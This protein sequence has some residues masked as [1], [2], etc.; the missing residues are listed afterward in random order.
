MQLV[1]LF[2]SAAVTEPFCGL[3]GHA[4]PEAGMPLWCAKRRGLAPHLALSQQQELL[5]QS[6]TYL[7]WQHG[8]FKAEQEA[9]I[10]AQETLYLLQQNLLTVSAALLSAAQAF[11]AGKA[12][13]PFATHVIA[14]PQKPDNCSLLQFLLSLSQCQSA[15]LNTGVDTQQLD[16]KSQQILQNLAANL[17]QKLSLLL[18]GPNTDDGGLVDSLPRLHS[19]SH[20]DIDALLSAK[21]N[22]FWQEQATQLAPETGL[23]FVDNAHAWQGHKT[24]PTATP[25]G[26]LLQAGSAAPHATLHLAGLSHDLAKLAQATR[27]AVLLLDLAHMF[28]ADSARDKFSAE[29]AHYFSTESAPFRPLA[30][31]YDGLAEII[32]AH[33]LSAESQEGKA[34]AG[35]LMAYISGIAWQTSIQLAQQH[36]AF[37]AYATESASWLRVLRN[38]AAAAFGEQYHY[39]DVAVLPRAVA[40]RFCP[41]ANLLQASLSLWAHIPEAAARFGLR[42]AHILQLGPALP[43]AELAAQIDWLAAQQPFACGGMSEP[44]ICTQALTASEWQNLAVSAWQ[45]GLKCWRLAMQ[46]A[47]IAL[48]K[49]PNPPA[50]AATHALE[51][52]IYRARREIMPNPRR[53]TT[54]KISIGGEKLFL[55]T[56]TYADGRLGEVFMDCPQADATQKAL[57]D[58]FAICLSIGLQ[59]GV[60]LQ[61]YV[62]NLSGLSFGPQGS[63]EGS[64]TVAQACSMVDY[65][66]RELAAQHSAS[67]QV[68]EIVTLPIG[69]KT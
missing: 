48:A 15:G 36:G 40:G 29:S 2:T 5:V 11:T 68:A 20:R 7:G 1:R 37:P 64:N 62:D 43:Q 19:L 30:L 39:E 56:G 60:P 8:I 26:A 17:P 34:Y 49:A 50:P 25:L 42:H 53:G 69:K 65:V 31:A 54:Y 24:A 6:L 67:P 47:S 45:A 51:K 41:D 13:Q 59:Y 55:R 66:M 44:L 21:N 33:K 4:M 28:S 58:T 32:Q 63:V 18:C 16:T 61:D 12:A 23:F 35:C 52:I 10:F 14:A 22:A 27:L 9:R 38:R 57:L 3:G 46:H